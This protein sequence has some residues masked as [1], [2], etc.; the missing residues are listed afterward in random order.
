VKSLRDNP[1]L[2]E[3]MAEMNDLLGPLGLAGR[4]LLDELQIYNEALKADDILFLFE[5]PTRHIN[6]IPIINIF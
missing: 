2:R 1:R 4:G 6:T 5:Q 3:A